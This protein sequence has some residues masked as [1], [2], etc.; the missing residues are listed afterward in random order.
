MTPNGLALTHRY[1]INIPV[2]PHVDSFLS[3]SLR[4]QYDPCFTDFAQAFLSLPER[5]VHYA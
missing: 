4:D 1:I 5:G 2:P 3:Q